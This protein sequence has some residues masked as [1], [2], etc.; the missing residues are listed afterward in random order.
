MFKLID[1]GAFIL[2]SIGVAIDALD[3]GAAIDCLSLESI[4]IGVLYKWLPK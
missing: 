2:I 1:E 3:E 4:S